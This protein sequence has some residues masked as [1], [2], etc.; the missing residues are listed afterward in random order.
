MHVLQD[1]MLVRVLDVLDLAPYCTPAASKT[2]PRP[3]YDLFGLVCHSGTLAGGHY[4]A[5]VRKREAGMPDTWMSYN[6]AFTSSDRPI[7]KDSKA[8][9]LMFYRMRTV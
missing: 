3:L 8:V 1:N 6:D 4:T 9:Y 2:Y 5:S 7:L